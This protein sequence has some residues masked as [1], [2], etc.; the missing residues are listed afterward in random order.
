MS[1][2]ILIVRPGSKLF[3]FKTNQLLTLTYLTD[4]CILDYGM[5][6]LHM[7]FRDRNV[8]GAVGAIVTVQVIIIVY[9][10][11][12]LREPD[13]RQTPQEAKLKQD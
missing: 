3:K 11:K 8:I 10:I 2:E 6:L 5:P 9:I 13:D 12:A 1:S 4:C 7:Q